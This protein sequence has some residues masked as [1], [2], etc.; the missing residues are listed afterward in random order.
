MLQR[1]KSF[2]I[3]IDLLQGH[4]RLPGNFFPPDLKKGWICFC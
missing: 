4:S 2:S 3:L 1:K